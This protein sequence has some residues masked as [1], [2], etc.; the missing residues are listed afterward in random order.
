M[1]EV[2]RGLRTRGPGAIT[3]RGVC[4]ALVDGFAENAFLTY[5][6]AVSFQILTAII[7]FVLF[8]LAL[9]DALHLGGRS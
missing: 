9:A 6:S 5:A 7:P 8:V 3:A 1:G 4:R 2:L